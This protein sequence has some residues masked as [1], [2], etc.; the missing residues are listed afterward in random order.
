[1]SYTLKAYLIEDT[2]DFEDTDDPT[3]TSTE[4]F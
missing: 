3:D 1:M 2:D 4:N